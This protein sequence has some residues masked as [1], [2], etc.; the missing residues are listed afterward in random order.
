LLAIRVSIKFLVS[1]EEI[2]GDRWV[3][4]LS[5]EKKGRKALFPLKIRP[6]LLSPPRN[7]PWHRYRTCQRTH[8]SHG[9]GPGCRRWLLA[10]PSPV[11]DE[12]DRGRGKARKHGSNERGSRAG[13]SNLGTKEQ[14]LN[15]RCK[16]T[17]VKKKPRPSPPRNRSPVIRMSTDT[18]QLE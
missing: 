8:P 4:S 6:H 16:R 15:S 13:H 3:V 7:S 9:I 5:R 11:G 17:F 14:R 2:S 1:I 18:S 12:A 10:A